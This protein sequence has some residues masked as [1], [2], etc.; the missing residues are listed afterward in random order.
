MYRY[1]WVTLLHRSNE[2]SIVNQLDSNNNNRDIIALH[3]DRI[4][5]KLWV[6]N[7]VYWQQCVEQR[8]LEG[9]WQR[10]GKWTVTPLQP[11]PGHSRETLSQV[12]G[13]IWY[14]LF[15]EQ[16]SLWKAL[17]QSEASNKVYTQE[18]R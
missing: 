15:A 12:P 9:T 8:V 7:A 3:S 5:E 13:G 1:N 6:G 14:P 18:Q 11:T 10:E 17:Q 2:H 16:L 4:G